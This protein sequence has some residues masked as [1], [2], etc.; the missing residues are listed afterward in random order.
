MMISASPDNLCFQFKRLE[1]PLF[2]PFLFK[3]DLLQYVSDVCFCRLC[4][5]KTNHATLH[6]VFSPSIEIDVIERTVYC[7]GTVLDFHFNLS[8]LFSFQPF[9]THKQNFS[10]ACL[11]ST[12]ILMI[13]VSY[14]RG[15]KLKI[16]NSL[17]PYS[18]FH[19]HFNHLN[20]NKPFTFIPWEKS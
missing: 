11:H 12:H 10:P 2:P 7:L 17:Y 6:F 1:M 3:Y 5:F 9:S 20:L 8:I 15:K 4:H 19:I 18:I 13:F 16:K 14:F